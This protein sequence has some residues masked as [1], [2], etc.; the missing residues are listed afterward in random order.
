MASLNSLGVGLIL[1]CLLPVGCA[2]HGESKVDS[3]VDSS[4]PLPSRP[5]GQTG[6]WNLIFH[7]EF[8]GD[9]LDTSKWTTCYW[10]DNQGC[11]NEGNNNL[12]WYQPDNV[13]L[14]DGKLI[15]RAKE[16]KV[17]SPDG[18]QYAYTSGMVTTGRDSSALSDEPRA[19]FQYVY[20]EMKAKVPLGQGL[21]PAF[22][23]LPADHES[24]PEIDV[25]EMLG[26]DPYSVHMNFHYL[27][28]YG[29]EN[30]A[31]YTWMSP[32]PL[33]GW[34]VF[35]HDWQPGALTWYIDGVKHSHLEDY[36]PDEPMYL[37]ANLAVGG[38][39]PGSPDSS[40][41]FPSKFEIDYIRVWARE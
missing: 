11:T 8:N 38:D 33:T 39:W 20:V 19:T 31:G 5:L 10:W 37:L 32:E 34:H 24:R 14:K 35:A 4:Q 17:T 40:T 6:E 28:K 9:T 26:D 21:W 15:L 16:E 27:D 22:W 2:S 36:I 3:R 18:K 13:F 1:C 29:D 12:N 7:D 23:L 30:S 41:P 25:M